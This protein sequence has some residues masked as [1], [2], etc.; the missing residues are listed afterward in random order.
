MTETRSPVLSPVT[1]L[2]SADHLAGEFVAEHVAVLAAV[3]GILG[4]VQVA[5][6]DAAA[7]DLDHDLTRSGRGVGQGFE[8]QRGVQGLEGYGFH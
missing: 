5:A 6:A 3:G 8:G 4:H 2:P 1:S 7:A